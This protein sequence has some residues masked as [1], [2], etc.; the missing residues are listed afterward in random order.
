MMLKDNKPHTNYKINHEIFKKYKTTFFME[1]DTI[2]S[3]LDVGDS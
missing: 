3:R 1:L 2:F